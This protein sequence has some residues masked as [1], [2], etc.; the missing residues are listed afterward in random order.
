MVA[1]PLAILVGNDFFGLLLAENLGDHRGAV[2]EWG[3]GANRVTVGV[4]QHL[5]ESGLAASFDSQLLDL[6][7]VT[8]GD[9]V[10]FAASF[11]DCVCHRE[12]PGKGRRSWHA[13]E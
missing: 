3:A 9:A 13:Q 12:I 2:E 10:L 4:E 5:R 8:L 6:N 1:F 7:D 11:D